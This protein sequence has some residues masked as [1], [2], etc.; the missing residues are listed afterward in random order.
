MIKLDL[1][2]KS[3]NNYNKVYKKYEKDLD[4]FAQKVFHIIILINSLILDVHLLILQ[5]MRK[6]GENF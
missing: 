3:S 5:K 4:N 6:E 2:K 1:F